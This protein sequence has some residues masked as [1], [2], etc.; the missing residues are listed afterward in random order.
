MVAGAAGAAVVAAS[1][2]PV[3]VAMADTIRTVDYYQT[4]VHEEPAAAYHLLAR[5]ADA[6]VNLLA[7]NA[8]PVGMHAMQLVLF[9]EEGAVLPQV[10]ASLGLAATG[11]HR[12][13][14]VQGD[15]QLGALAEI[16]RRLLELGVQPYAS[17]G[18]TDGRGG[19]A[20]IVHV[21]A[22]QFDLVKRSLGL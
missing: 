19:H 4:T 12:A 22:E 14:L 17:S 18:V 8:I 1:R 2:P 13:L 9:P 10:V 5:L 21:R 3:G 6:G 16:H 7:F 20:V 11:P 15:D